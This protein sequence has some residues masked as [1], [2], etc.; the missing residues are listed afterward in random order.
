M[1]FSQVCEVQV[2]GEVVSGNWLV[3]REAVRIDVDGDLWR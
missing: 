2:R 1:E 3:G